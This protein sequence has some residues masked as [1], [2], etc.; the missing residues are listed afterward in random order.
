MCE[1]PHSFGSVCLDLSMFLVLFLYLLGRWVNLYLLHRNG[2]LFNHYFFT[3]KHWTLY[4]CRK[5]F[6]YFERI[7]IKCF[8]WFIFGLDITKIILTSQAVREPW[9]YQYSTTSIKCISKTITEL[10]FDL[11]K[12]YW[13][14]GEVGSRRPPF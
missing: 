9:K 10:E 3:K 2:I 7:F 1:I 11:F 8:Y 4:Y 14:F 5:Y 12:K 13:K 6:S